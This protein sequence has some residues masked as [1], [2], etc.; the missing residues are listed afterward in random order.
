MVKNFLFKINKRI[1]QKIL[2]RQN[3]LAEKIPIRQNILVV[4]KNDRTYSVQ[5]KIPFLSSETIFCNGIVMELLGKQGVLTKEKTE[6]KNNCRQMLCTQLQ[7][8]WNELLIL[9]TLYRYLEPEID[10]L[11]FNS[12]TS[13]LLVSSY[14]G[15]IFK[16]VQFC[17]KNEKMWFYGRI[18]WWK[19][20][21]SVPDPFRDSNSTQN[22][23]K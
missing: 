12:C 8:F 15:V 14:W 4:P 10:T 23:K 11:D 13:L 17:F 1:C 7:Y 19:H 2:R 22:Q 5:G 16:K 18:S 9:S 20:P 3:I 6:T 21:R